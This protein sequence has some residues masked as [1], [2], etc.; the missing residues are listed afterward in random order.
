MEEYAARREIIARSFSAQLEACVASFHRLSD[1]E[2]TELTRAALRRALIEFLA[3]FPI[4]RTYATASERP[5]RDR[6]FLEAAVAGARAT[7]LPAD[8]A[9][10]DTL[11]TWL[12]ERASDPEAVNIQDRA[13][14]QFQQLSAP[15]AA[16]AVE[17]TAFYR[18]GRLL[19]RNDVGFEADVL[20]IEAWHFHA[21]VLRR[22]A[23]FPDAMLAT[24]THD[25]KRGEDVRARLA[26]LSEKAEEWASVLPGWIERCRP[27]R[28][29]SGD[30]LLPH[31]GD[32]AMLFQTIVGAW[33]LD[34]E[35]RN[36]E[37][38]R[39]FAERLARWQE[40]ALREA[41]LATDWSV[42]NQDYEIRGAAPH[43]GPRCGQCLGRPAERHRGVRQ[44]H[45]RRRRGQRSR[46]DFAEAHRRRAC[47]TSIRAQ[48]AGTSAWST[49]TIAGRWIL[50]L[51]CRIPTTL[52]SR[53]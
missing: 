36:L 28:R 26:V 22:Q 46:A 38:R 51:A 12:G 30:A 10:V 25:H 44:P 34:L 23:D 45:Q 14:T 20:G 50:R 21:R 32:I 49:P 47:R 39:S 41:K 18:Y 35:V 8:R 37:G 31:G 3:H 17:D 4:Y 15:I 42:P 19:S 43:D 16:K 13:V 33:P 40:K 27:L 48:S 52:L 1:L 7:C 5:A 9:V 2:G 24:A 6:H 53:P 29:Q 11:A